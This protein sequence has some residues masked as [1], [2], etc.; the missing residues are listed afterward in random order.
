V[1]TPKA[2]EGAQYAVDLILKHRVMPWGQVKTDVRDKASG[3]WVGS[4]KVAMDW[5]GYWKI[6]DAAKA[7]GDDMGVTPIPK[8]PAGKATN[9]VAGNA[10]SILGLSKV[11]DAA[12]EIMR[13]LIGKP[14][15]DLWATTTFPA[16][17]ASA[18]AYTKTFP[19]VNWDPLINHWAK[20]GRDYMV[21]PDASEFWTESGKALGPM[22][23]GKTT[24]QEAMKASA[25]AS[26]EVFKKRP[27]ELK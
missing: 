4:G 3:T 16:L 2:I 27:P 11:K 9:A 20:E 23:E 5:Y 8:G 21:T 22:F 10:W 17:I 7:L 15:Q 26:N 1:T 24:V 13:V 14:G 18:P 25:A 6:G 19:K 12:W